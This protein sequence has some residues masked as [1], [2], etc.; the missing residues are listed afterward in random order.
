MN[1]NDNIQACRALIAAVI[2][3]AIED[4]KNGII[5]KYTY[6]KDFISA[7]LFLTSK[8]RLFREYCAL[9]DINP[10]YL[11]E[12]IKKKYPINLLTDINA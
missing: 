4:Y 2:N 3:R 8:N 9:I 5:K 10:K 6:N 12:K 1:A 11:E 7:K